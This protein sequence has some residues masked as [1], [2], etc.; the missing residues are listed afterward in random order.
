MSKFDRIVDDGLKH[1]LPLFEDHPEV[2]KFLRDMSFAVCA[3]LN[4][5]TPEDN[6]F[7]RQLVEKGIRL[8][9]ANFDAILQ[10]VKILDPDF[11][12]ACSSGCSY[13]CSSHISLMPHEAF[14]IALYLAQNCDESE[15]TRYTEKCI[16]AAAPL[17]IKSL[18]SFVKDYFSPCPF[19]HENRCSIYDVR[20]I[21]CRNWISSDLNACVKSHEGQNK[22]VVPQNAMVMVQKDLIFTGQRAYLKKYGINGNL[23]SFLPLLSLIMIDFEGTYKRWLSGEVLQGQID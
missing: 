18:K 5:I 16:E 2:I 21:V 7:P 10:Q 19:L 13:C 1:V 22:V 4:G 14:N 20:P 8:F 11:E 9:E 3:D 12:L 15:F 17:E 6:L 23:G